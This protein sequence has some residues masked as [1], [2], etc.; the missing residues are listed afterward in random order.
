MQRRHK[1]LASP[2]RAAAEVPERYFSGQGGSPWEV[3]GE[4][5]LGSPAYRARTRKENQI[6]PSCEKQQVSVSQGEMAGDTENLLKGQCTKFCLQP[7]TLGSSRGR[8]GWTKD[9]WGDS[10][11]GGSRERT[12]GTTGRI[13]VLS[14][15]PWCRSRF[16][17]AENSSLN[18]NSWGEAIALHKGITLPHPVELKPGSR[19]AWLQLEGISLIVLTTKADLWEHGTTWMKWINS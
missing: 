1:R 15:F 7:L 19:T 12:E 9:T 10:G 3:W 16:C 2:P 5:K 6:T 18:G 14:H 13:P 17:Q 11:A 8:A 4:P